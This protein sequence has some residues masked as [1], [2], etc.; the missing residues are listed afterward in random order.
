[1]KSAA[2]IVVAFE[3]KRRRPARTESRLRSHA[4][5]R[6]GQIRGLAALQQ[7]NHDHEETDDDVDQWSKE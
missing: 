1:M 7:H 2:A 6:A 4:A 5:E 3:S